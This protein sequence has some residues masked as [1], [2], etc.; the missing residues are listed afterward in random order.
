VSDQI[1]QAKKM[2]D[3]LKHDEETKAQLEKHRVVQAQ[4]QKESQ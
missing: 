4:R 2:M 3:F 1:A